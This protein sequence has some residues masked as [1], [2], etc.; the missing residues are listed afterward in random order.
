MW[1]TGRARAVQLIVELLSNLVYGVSDSSGFPAGPFINSIDKL[2]TGDDIGELPKSTSSSPSFLGAHG[3]LVH[4][5]EPALCAHA[6]SGLRGPQADGCERRFDGIGRADVL[7]VRGREVVEG[8]QRGAI[9]DQ[10]IDRLGVFVLVVGHEAIEG[11]VR[12]RPTVGLPDLVQR[13]FGRTLQALGELV[14]HVDGFVHPAALL[15]RLRVQLCQRRPEAQRTVADE[16]VR[17]LCV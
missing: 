2:H 10:A 12:G 14:E 16:P 15:A 11:L 13:R 8:Q 17:I 1:G 7:E 5:T 4:E 3:E 6:V 9:L